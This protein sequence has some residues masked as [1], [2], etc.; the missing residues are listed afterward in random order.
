MNVILYYLIFI[1]TIGFLSMG[2]D[3]YKAKK[4]LWRTKEKTLF[5]IAIIGGSVGSILGMQ[6]FRHKTKHLSFT[7]GFPIIFLIQFAAIFLYWIR[8][9]Y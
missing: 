7:L 2:Y 3:K 5:F 4:Q 8:W 1:N 9:I 6:V